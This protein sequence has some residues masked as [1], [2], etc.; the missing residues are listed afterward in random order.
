M[1][2][3]QQTHVIFVIYNLPWISKKKKNWIKH[4]CDVSTTAFYF[5]QGLINRNGVW[6]LLNNKPCKTTA[7]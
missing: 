4:E 6:E 3:L 5:C 2:S 1:I 7:V